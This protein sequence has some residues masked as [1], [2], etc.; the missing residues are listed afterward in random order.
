MA[1]ENNSSSI[2]KDED[3]VTEKTP[4]LFYLIPAL[5]VLFVLLLAILGQVMN[6]LEYGRP[7]RFYNK[8]TIVENIQK[9]TYCRLLGCMLL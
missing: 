2:I 4:L 6:Q 5:Y 8:L 1:P 3:V 7:R 9:Y